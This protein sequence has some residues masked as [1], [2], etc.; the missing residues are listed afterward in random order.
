MVFSTNF[1]VVKDNCTSTMRAARILD[2]VDIWKVGR[3]EGCVA[4]V[5]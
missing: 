5:R 3:L 2:G 4:G 1:N